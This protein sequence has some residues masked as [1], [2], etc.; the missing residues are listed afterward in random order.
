V[1]Y[2]PTL[3]ALRPGEEELRMARRLLGRL[4]MRRFQDPPPRP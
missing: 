2:L 4:G 3:L 1:V